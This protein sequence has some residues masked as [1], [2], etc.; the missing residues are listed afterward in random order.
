MQCFIAT[1]VSGAVMFFALSILLMAFQTRNI[2]ASV[3]GLAVLGTG[4]FI[5]KIAVERV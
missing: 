3:I 5:F 4:I 2:E 1:T